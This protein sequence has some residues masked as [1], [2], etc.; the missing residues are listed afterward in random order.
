MAARLVIV[1]LLAAVLMSVGACA[2][3]GT[4]TPVP[5]VPVQPDREELVGLWRGSDERGYLRFSGDGTLVV[6][7]T[8]ELLNSDSPGVYGQ[9]RLEVDL[10]KV[11]DNIC[12]KE[13]T[14]RVVAFEKQAD[15]TVWMQLRAVN[16][17][18]QGGER[19]EVLAGTWRRVSQ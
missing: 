6:G 17:T 16:D 4:P 7:E 10:L 8:L 19:R 5:T 11:S 1:V 12:D 14:Y 3:R 15:G 13:G 9:Y 2:S 18:C